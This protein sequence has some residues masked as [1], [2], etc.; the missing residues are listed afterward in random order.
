[1]DAVACSKVDLDEELVDFLIAPVTEDTPSSDGVSAL[2]Y[3]P[4]FES[5]VK[6]HPVLSLAQ[7]K[8]KRDCDNRV[9][10]S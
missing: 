9:Q 1:M 2:E 5:L 6:S 4:P 8:A 10:L 3:H 7:A